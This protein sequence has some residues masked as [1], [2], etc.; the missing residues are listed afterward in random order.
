M[1]IKMLRDYYINIQT[2]DLVFKYHPNNK[3]R[4]LTDYILLVCR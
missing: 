2:I 4:K 3:T 1:L